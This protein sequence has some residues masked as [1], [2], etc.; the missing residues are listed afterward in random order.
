MNRPSKARSLVTGPR[1]PTSIPSRTHSCSTEPTC[2]T[3]SSTNQPAAQ[4]SLTSILFPQ[5]RLSPS[6]R[7]VRARRPPPRSRSPPQCGVIMSGSNTPKRSPSSSPTTN[8]RPSSRQKTS[9][10]AVLAAEDDS[11]DG[12][13]LDHETSL[14]GMYQSG[15]LEPSEQETAVYPAND[16]LNQKV[17]VW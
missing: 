2:L 17:H 16:N 5:S 8:E 14:K 1:P 9:P 10:N 6:V 12:L 7:T 4:S 13:V 11:A 3:Y 15:S